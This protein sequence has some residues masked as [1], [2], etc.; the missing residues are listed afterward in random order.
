VEENKRRD[1]ENAVKARII[2]L[3]KNRLVTT[4][5]MLNLEIES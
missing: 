4:K 1:A 3:E 2:E 5:Q